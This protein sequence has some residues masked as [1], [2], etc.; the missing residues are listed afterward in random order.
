MVIG[1]SGLVLCRYHARDSHRCPR[2]IQQSP[3]EPLE[4]EDQHQH[5]SQRDDNY[6]VN[7]AGLS[8][9]FLYRTI[10]MDLAAQE[11][12]A[13]CRHQK[14]RQWAGRHFHHDL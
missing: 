3:F 2:H 10:K 1:T 12:G 6:R 8:S 4:F 14:F 7:S 11:E 13:H 9:R 5:R